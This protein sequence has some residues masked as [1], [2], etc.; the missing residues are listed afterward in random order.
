MG[1]V[2]M[3]LP[4]IVALKSFHSAVVGQQESPGKHRHELLD[5]AETVP[6]EDDGAAKTRLLKPEST[7]REQRW[8]LNRGILKTAGKKEQSTTC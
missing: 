6:R 7:S 4:P 1:I 8:K 5:R 3:S 2:A